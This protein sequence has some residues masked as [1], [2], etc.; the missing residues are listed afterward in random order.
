MSRIRFGL[1]RLAFGVLPLLLAFWG[2]AFIVPTAQAGTCTLQVVSSVTFRSR[3][4]G[5]PMEPL[6]SASIWMDVE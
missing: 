1:T 4:L 3:L 6:R 2:S 5:I